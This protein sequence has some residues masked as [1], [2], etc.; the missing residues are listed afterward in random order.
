MKIGLS[1]LSNLLLSCKA[2]FTSHSRHVGSPSL[3]ACFSDSDIAF[4]GVY[5]RSS[6]G[7]PKTA[8]LTTAHHIGIVFDSASGNRC[9]LSKCGYVWKNLTHFPSPGGVYNDEAVEC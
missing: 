5:R 8:E 7:I 9:H 4:G 2:E 3:I 6:A 1:G